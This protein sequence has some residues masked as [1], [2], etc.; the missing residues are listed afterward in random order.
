VI[1]DNLMNLELLF[2]ATEL[3]DNPDFYDVAVAHANTTLRE[4]FRADNSSFHVVDFNPATGQVNERVTHQGFADESA[5]ARGQAW[6][7]YG[8]TMCYRFTQDP[9]YLKQ[10]EK[11]ADFMFAHPNLPKDKIPVWDY[12]F[13]ED[14]GEPRDASAAAIAASA[15][16]ELSQYVVLRKDEF[17]GLANDI[18][19]ALEQ[20]YL[21]KPG[22]NHGFLLDYSVGN[23][24]KDGEVNVPIN[25]ADYYFLEALLRQ[26]DSTNVNY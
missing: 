11:I 21:S 26:R 17:S 14:S 13:S 1:I 8:Y 9:V 2:K 23:K 6:G 25:Y 3:T 24:P 19:S 5:W 10:A 7:L 16:L 4:H 18:L 20:N 15:L 12:A 22:T